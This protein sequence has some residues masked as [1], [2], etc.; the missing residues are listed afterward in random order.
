MKIM[1]K[2]IQLGP[3]PKTTDRPTESPWQRVIVPK[4]AKRNVTEKFAKLIMSA[5]Q[6]LGTLKEI[7]GD[8][9]GHYV[10]YGPA[11]EE[12]SG[13][14]RDDGWYASGESE[15]HDKTPFDYDYDEDDQ[16]DDSITDYDGRSSFL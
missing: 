6:Q 7:L 1:D 3:V 12:E 13:G 16:D 11:S 5:K 10:A 9:G 14:L 2:Y 8:N 4:S 15:N